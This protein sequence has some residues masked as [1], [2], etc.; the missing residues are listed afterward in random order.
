ML[1]GGTLRRISP[2]NKWSSRLSHVVNASSAPR[3]SFTGGQEAKGYSR[4]FVKRFVAP[5]QSPSSAASKKL[6]KAGGVLNFRSRSSASAWRRLAATN[7]AN[8]GSGLFRAAGFG[9]DALAVGFPAVPAAS[10][11]RQEVS[12]TAA[13]RTK[14]NRYKTCF[15]GVSYEQTRRVN[16]W[17]L[18]IDCGL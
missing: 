6:Q 17:N 12:A 9:M 16:Q 15:T 10:G 14:A 3:V 4:I 13:R 2:P 18:A 5:L 1:P 11:D 8:A 7:L